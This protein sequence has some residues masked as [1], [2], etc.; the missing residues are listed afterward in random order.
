MKPAYR[1]SQVIS[2]MVDRPSKFFGKILQIQ[3]KSLRMD[4]FEKIKAFVREIWSRPFYA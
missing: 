2:N 4:S 3:V 1:K